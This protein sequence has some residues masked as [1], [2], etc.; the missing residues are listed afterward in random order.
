MSWK[1]GAIIGLIAILSMAVIGVTYAANG[2]PGLADKSLCTFNW[3]ESNDD[4]NVGKRNVYNPIDPGDN[5][6]DPKAAQTPGIISSR[7][8]ANIASLTETHTTDTITFNLDN[9]YPGYYPT[10]FF[11]LSNQWTTPGIVQSI[12]IQNSSP[13][14]LAVDLKGILLNQ[15]ID[16]GH[17]AVGALSIGVGDIPQSKQTNHYTLSVTIVVT[18]WVTTVH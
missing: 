11:G 18:Q 17:E 10:L 12:N 4:G 16:A 7:I 9:A 6:N 3:V 14:L 8:S 15:V 2:N 5:G 13:S 1:I